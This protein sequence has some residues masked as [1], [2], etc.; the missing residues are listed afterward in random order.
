MLEFRSAAVLSRGV[1]VGSIFV[2]VISSSIFEVSVLVTL[3]WKS[4]QVEQSSVVKDQ[5]LEPQLCV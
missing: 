5:E 1:D 4:S 3:C 2:S